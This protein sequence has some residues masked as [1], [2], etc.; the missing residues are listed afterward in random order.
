VASGRGL[1]AAVDELRLN[2]TVYLVD[3]AGNIHSLS[4]EAYE[5]RRDEFPGCYVY[6]IRSCAEKRAA[7]IKERLS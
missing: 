1:E 4:P 7:K 6:V 5:K 3:S 2:D